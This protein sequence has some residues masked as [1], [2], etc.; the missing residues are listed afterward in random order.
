MTVHANT[1]GRVLVTGGTG[2]VG[3]HLCPLLAQAWPHAQRRLLVRPGEGTERPGFER[4]PV[5]LCDAGALEEEVARF[6]PDLVVHLAAQS[7]VGAARDATGQTWRVNVGATLALAQA[8]A[9]H[10]PAATL[11][12]AS[13]AEVYGASLNEGPADESAVPRP[14]NCYGRSKWAAEMAL[15]D[16]LGPEATL[17][18]A[19]SFNHTGPGQDTRF[20]VPAFAAQIAGIEG[21]ALTPELRVGNLEARRDFLDV[22]DVVEA[23]VAMIRT[24][25][26]SGRDVFNVASGVGRRIG[27]VLEG[28]RALSTRPFAIL[29]DPARDRPAEIASAVGRADKLRARTGWA[30]RVDWD[31]TLR[32]VLDDHRRRAGLR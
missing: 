6:R 29:L 15:G 7:S 1:F 10:A 32:D 4:R 26:K 23:Y 30:P 25:P 17:V 12:F 16:V 20:A 11:F 21:G 9:R 3:G 13:T 22:R 19:R 18:I 31:A 8:C 5:D 28:L 24:A 14:A 27:D 2:F